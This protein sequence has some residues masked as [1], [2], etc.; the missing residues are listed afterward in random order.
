MGEEAALMCPVTLLSRACPVLATYRRDLDVRWLCSHVLECREQWDSLG[1]V[2]L[3]EV[4]VYRGPCVNERCD[5]P[6][7]IWRHCWAE[8]RMHRKG[9]YFA[10]T[11][12]VILSV[13]NMVLDPRGTPR[14]VKSPSAPPLLC[15]A[16]SW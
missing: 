12:G 13:P 16:L 9:V 15:E 4:N 7:P 6:T 1:G 5:P 14:Y 8:K 10:L 11:R 2:T 3:V